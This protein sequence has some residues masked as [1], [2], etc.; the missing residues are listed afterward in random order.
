MGSKR[1]EAS[2]KHPCL[3]SY[4]QLSESE[5]EYDRIAAVG[6][7]KTILALGFQIEKGR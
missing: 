6:V 1:D 7:L 3:V 2:K 4:A 5:K